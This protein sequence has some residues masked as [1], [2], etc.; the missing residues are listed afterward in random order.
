MASRCSTRTNIT[1]TRGPP[2][3]ARRCCNC[4]TNWIRNGRPVTASSW[5]WRCSSA[6]CSAC[7]A[8]TCVKRSAVVL[9]LSESSRS[10]GWRG[11][12]AETKRPCASACAWASVARKGRSQP[13][14]TAAATRAASAHKAASQAAVR[15]QASHSA[16]CT[17]PAWVSSV[18]S[19]P[20]PPPSASLARPGAATTGKAAMNQSGA[21]TGAAGRR[22]SSSGCPSGA[23]S[24]RRRIWPGSA[25]AAA[26]ALN[27]AEPPAW[28]DSRAA[29]AMA[30]SR[31]RASSWPCKAWRRPS[32]CNT[33]L[34]TH[35]ASSTPANSH[36]MRRASVTGGAPGCYR[37]RCGRP[38]R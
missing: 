20:S 25:C 32:A 6:T 9:R 36:A 8:S 2:G 35:A 24:K 16:S 28:R 34:P 10:S 21:A 3:S 7:A 17:H 33:R 11:G 15:E 12:S 13:R 26:A 18:R 31:L 19:P 22:R 14:S 5:A 27:A 23:R 4:S 38:A 29:S 1:A 30:A 37:K